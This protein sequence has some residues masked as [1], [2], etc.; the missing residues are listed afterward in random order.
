[1][2]PSQFDHALRAVRDDYPI[3][4]TNAMLNLIDSHDTNRALY[5]LTELGDSGLTQAKQRLELSALFQFTYLGAPMVM[6]GDEVAINSPSLSSSSNG[7]IGDPYTRAP[8]PWTD[9]SG[10]PTIYGPPDAS[11]ENFYTKLAHLRKQYPALRTG[12][13][14]TLLTG[15]TQQAGTA[16]NTY[17]FARTLA[18][19]A[20]VVALNN[21]AASNTA[22]IPVAGIFAD[23]TQLQDALSGSTYSVATGS[24]AVTL[25]A[26]SG[27][28]LLP[29][30]ASVDLIAP[31]ASVSIVPPPNG[32]GFND[33]SPVTV[34]LTATD[35]GGSGVSQLRYWVNQGP[36]NVAPGASA[37]FNLTGPGTFVVNVRAVD[38]A[39]NISA[40]VS[41]TVK[42]D[43]TPPT[44]TCSVS[45]SS[46]WP[47][48]GKLVPVTATVTVT[49]AISGPAGFT[50]ISATSNEPPVG[51]SIQ[52]FV[53]GTPSIHGS[54]KA[55]RNGSGN[56]RVYTLTYQGMNNAGLSATCSVTVTVPHDQGH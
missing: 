36:T 1:M 19:A 33:T 34:N 8:Y 21:G 31:V 22:S 42:I 54:M 24:V 6:Y 39:G 10:D 35:T 43:L 41:R 44:V 13:F 4:A 47:P 37:S 9:Q 30:P 55:E 49:D 51:D 5:L 16:A 18:G 15:D 2:T 52:G 56:G 27:V 38:N 25:G 28:V 3:P 40:L 32:S 50:L 45:P 23:G 7:P 29:S 14:T 12:A 53:I 17:A 46:L 26:R 20:A 48:N 11:V